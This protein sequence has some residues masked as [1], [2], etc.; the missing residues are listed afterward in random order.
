M[1]KPGLILIG[2]G[3][4]ARVCID[5]IEQHDQFAVAGL[6]GMPDEVHTR[7]L[8]YEVLATDDALAELAGQFRYALVTV[9]QIASSALRMRLYEQ[10]LQLGFVL[11]AIIAPGAFV[12]RHASVGA[13]SIVM[14]G[15]IVN[16]GARIGYNCIVNTRAIVEH[17][18][19]LGDHCHLA[20]GAILN[21]AVTVGAGSFV[22]SGSI[23]KQG[24][25]IGARS[26]V[27]MG[28]SVRHDVADHALFLGKP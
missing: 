20:T 10:A 15:A 17:D 25:G 27:G 3:G 24:I 6:V 26:I 7:M 19:V 12:S 13:G 2:A 21:G 5:V 9:G 8:G 4:H 14:H 23:V 22:G 16:A 28:L 1:S 18:A 11:P